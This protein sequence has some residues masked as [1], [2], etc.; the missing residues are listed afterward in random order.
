LVTFSGLVAR[1]SA[2]DV[3]PGVGDQLV[4]DRLAPLLDLVLV[5]VGLGGGEALLGRLAAVGHEGVGLAVIGVVDLRRAQDARAR[6]E[7]HVG[8][9]LEVPDLGVLR[10]QVRDLGDVR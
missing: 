1:A 9:I 7:R 8:R 2:V 4:L 6:E 5:Q 3:V 10:L